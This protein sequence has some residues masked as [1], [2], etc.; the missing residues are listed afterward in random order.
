[1]MWTLSIGTVHSNTKKIRMKLGDIR[2]IT[3]HSLVLLNTDSFSA[4]MFKINY[5]LLGDAP[6][7]VHL[8]GCDSMAYR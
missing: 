5:L 7:Q 3:I 6:Y 8:E 4:P 1:M 2:F